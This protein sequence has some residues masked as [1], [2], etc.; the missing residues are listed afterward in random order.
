MNDDRWSF[1][2]P[3]GMQRQAGSAP[4]PRAIKSPPV[5]PG[6][7]APEAAIHESDTAAAAKSAIEASAIG[8]EVRFDY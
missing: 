2:I 8:A 1:P 6:A 7:V 3:M 5:C 4:R